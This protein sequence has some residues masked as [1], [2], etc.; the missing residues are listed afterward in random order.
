MTTCRHCCFRKMNLLSSKEF[1]EIMGKGVFFYQFVVQDIFNLVV[2]P[3]HDIILF[4]ESENVQN[5][6]YKSA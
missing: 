4:A 3:V 1:L 6:I 2:F 5:V